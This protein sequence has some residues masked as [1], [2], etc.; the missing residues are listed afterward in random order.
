MVKKKPKPPPPKGMK[1]YVQ[2]EQAA[3]KA[4]ATNVKKAT[5]SN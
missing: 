2:G 3:H 5:K 1:A 4:K